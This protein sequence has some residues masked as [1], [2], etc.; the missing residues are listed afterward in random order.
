M[1]IYKLLKKHQYPIFI[2]LITLIFFYKIL[3]HPTQIIYPSLDM[4][5]Y[6]SS[7]NLFQET[8]RNLGDI[9]LWNPY[10]FGGTP[11]VGNLESAMF[12]PFNL[13]FLIFPTMQLFGFMF[14]LDIFLIGIFTYFFAREISLSKFSSLLS[15]I[16]MMFNG[17]TLLK[18]LPGHI[19]ILDGIVWL[20]LLLL[21][22][23]RGIK[24]RKTIYSFLSG[25]TIALMILAGNPQIALYGLFAAFL[26]L[27]F[28]LINDPKI[29]K[30]QVN[31]KNFV[32]LLI[33]P[34]LIGLSLS[35]IQLLPSVEFSKLSIRSNGLSYS[36]ASDFSLHP[37]QFITLLLPHFFGSPL[38]KD[39]YWGINGNFWELCGYVGILPIILAIISLFYKK[40]KYVIFF[41]FLALLSLLF[42]TGRFGF[43][44]E[45]FYKYIPGFNLFRAPARFLYLYAFSVSILAG[46][47]SNIFLENKLIKKNKIILKKSLVLL[48]LTTILSIVSLMIFS[49]QKQNINNFILHKGYALGNNLLQIDYLILKDLIIFTLIILSS[50][51]LMFLKVKNVL[52]ISFLKYLLIFIIMADLWLFSAK[53]YTTKNINSVVQNNN[54]TEILS[55]DKGY[56]RVFDFDGK[57]IDILSLNH[58]QSLTGFAALYLRNYRDFLWLS[59]GHLDTPYESFFSFNNINNLNIL[60]LLNTKYIISQKSLSESNKDLQKIGKNVYE[61]K[62]TFPRAYVVP[63]A[64][65]IKDKNKFLETINDKSFDF[66]ENVILEKYPDNPI[67][68]SSSYKSVQLIKYQPNE[69]KLKA[70]LDNPG[71]LVLS[72]VWYPGWKAYVNGKQT[73][74][75][76]AD[77]ILRSIYLNNGLNN[78]TF[79][80]DPLS[81]KIGK[82]IS[83]ISLTIIFT[84]MYSHYKKLWKIKSA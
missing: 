43:L 68:N 8:F 40:N 5:F 59:G 80:Y 23:E 16:V 52:K 18:I 30:K 81:Y 1:K 79:L 72:E 9:P 46:I 56:Y 6:L 27:A 41:F 44:Y 64:L 70:N 25:I 75:Y 55:K 14:I 82:F 62:E 63:N 13:L 65:V 83:L 45:A 71:F 54:I 74:I 28:R 22:Y 3:I 20:P 26:F 12:Y 4:N 76:K 60:R 2:L 37:Y 49:A 66:R 47:G 57:M 24:T 38:V 35:A 67:R 31:F 58:I 42:S 15:S 48:S 34:I 73:E 36:F 32:M 69:I 7:K 84:F 51:I 50:T 17:T 77:Y 29:R 21:F 61:V 19:F 33:F 78:I 39:T 11:F 53:F 10:S